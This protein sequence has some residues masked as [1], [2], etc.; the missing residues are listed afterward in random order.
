MRTAHAVRQYV[1]AVELLLDSQGASAFALTNPVQRIRR[2]MSAAARH[3]LNLPGL[4]QEMYGRS[5]LHADEQQMSPM[6]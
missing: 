3:S 6:A 2:D 4:K 5:L 1:T